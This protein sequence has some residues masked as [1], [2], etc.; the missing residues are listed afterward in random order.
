MAT[1]NDRLRIIFAF[2][3][4]IILAVTLTRVFVPGDSV[5]SAALPWVLL[6]LFWIYLFV[7][8]RRDRR[9]GRAE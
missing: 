2:A 5:W 4:V 9:G 3:G 7:M 6:V 8:T 1:S